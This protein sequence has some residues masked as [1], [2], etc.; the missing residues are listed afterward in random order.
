MCNDWYFPVINVGFNE[1]TT[2][3]TGTEGVTINVCVEIFNGT[4]GPGIELDYLIG[5]PRTDPLQPPGSQ[6]DTASGMTCLF[7][8]YNFC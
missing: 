2:D 3:N 4:L 7:S 8:V 6:P 5:A 1:N